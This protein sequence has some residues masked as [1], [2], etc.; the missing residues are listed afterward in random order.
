MA[1]QIKIFST[2]DDPK[3]LERE[4]NQ[5]MGKNRDIAI[6]EIVA[7]RSGDAE[8]GYLTTVFC[9]Y[10]APRQRVDEEQKSER[11]HER[12]HLF[13]IVDYMVADRYYRDFIEDMSESGVFIRTRHPFQVG[14]EIMIT[15]MSP[16][17]ERPLRV[18]GTIA[19]T[20][21]HGIGVEFKK[22]SQVQE[23]MIRTLLEKI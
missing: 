12:K 16:S 11:F 8:T 17:L 2:Y 13:D 18:G 19:R 5:W 7:D 1:K 22:Q 4:I 14:Q 9:L 6:G 15:F 23:D 20:L 3:D 10:E 21:P